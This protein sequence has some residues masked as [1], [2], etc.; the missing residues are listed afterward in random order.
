[1]TKRE[2]LNLIYKELKTTSIYPI[3]EINKTYSRLLKIAAVNGY[4]TKCFNTLWGRACN[5]NARDNGIY[6]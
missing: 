3:T 5:M 4:S 6:A 2:L 1:M